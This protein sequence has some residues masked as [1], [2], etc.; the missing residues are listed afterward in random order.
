M[1][2]WRDFYLGATNFFGG[3]GDATSFIN[4]NLT[5]VGAALKVLKLDNDF[6]DK[7]F[8][9]AGDINTVVVGF[10]SLVKLLDVAFWKELVQTFI[11][12]GKAVYGIF[13]GSG[14]DG[15]KSPGP[16]VPGMPGGDD[17]GTGQGTGP[18]IPG[19]TPV[20]GGGAGSAVKN[21]AIAAA[22][23][24]L[25]SKVFAGFQTREYSQ[26]ELDAILAQIAASNFAGFVP[27][28]LN[29]DGTEGIDWS[30]LQGGFGSAFD[31][32]SGDWSGRAQNITINLDGRQIAR[33]IMPYT[34]D[35]LMINGTT[36]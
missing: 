29:L 18:V 31:G 3:L 35:E 16:V 14:G 27:G 12:L 11:D 28:G 10:E 2:A 23:A 17:S 21:S 33:S 6:T 19:G 20:P 5:K 4:D 22:F 26:A 1:S 15:T 7:V 8:T 24:W 34:V 36:Y 13:A 25:G 30:W 32:G 9:L